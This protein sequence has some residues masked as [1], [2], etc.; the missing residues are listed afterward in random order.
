MTLLLLYLVANVPPGSCETSISET[1]SLPLNRHDTKKCGTTSYPW[2]IIAPRIGQRINVTLVD[3][4]NAS[5]KEPTPSSTS[6]ALCQRYIT[7][8]E[9]LRHTSRDVC[10]RRSVREN[11]VCTWESEMVELVFNMTAN[12]GEFLLI[13]TGRIRKY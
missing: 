5:I 8:N 13:V 9:P 12:I 7:V 11:F 3:L 1:N 6:A 10:V 2:R 4:S